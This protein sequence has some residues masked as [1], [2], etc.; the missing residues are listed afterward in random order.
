MDDVKRETYDTIILSGG[1][2]KGFCTLGALQYMQDNK[3]IVDLDCF[4]GSSIGSIISYFLAIGYTPIELMVSLCTNDVFESLK[5]NR[6]DEILTSGVYNY[7]QLRN[8]CERMTLDKIN[9][10][11]TLK[12]IK[13]K[14]NKEIIISTYNFTDKKQ[15]YI[16]YKN[17]PDIS[18]LDAIRMSSNLPFIFKPFF[19]NEKE[20]I[21]G[22]IVDNLPLSCVDS[23]QKSFGIY[24]RDKDGKDVNEPEENS[25]M[26]NMRNILDRIY[27]ILLIPIS[28]NIKNKLNAYRNEIDIL[29]IDVENVKMYTFNLSHSQK[30]ELFSLGYNKAKEHFNKK[31]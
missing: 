23:S 28:E 11:P 3:L 9:Y 25:T 30:L 15:E 14:F 22:G 7:D 6:I 17:Y 1:G 5:I 31:I 2:T 4:V 16:S 10:I 12:D 27:N 26:N 21:D 29:T 24:L 8:H 13:D 19:Y 18:S 20:Y